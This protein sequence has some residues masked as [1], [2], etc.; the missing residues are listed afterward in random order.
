MAA[1]K[2]FFRPRLAASGGIARPSRA[3]EGA[4]AR[5]FRELVLPHLDG[6]YNFARYLTRDPTAAE[7]DELNFV[8][9][10]YGASSADRFAGLFGRYF[11]GRI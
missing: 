9:L 8:R 3:D 10:V 1:Q 6:A 11:A 2:P 5:Q 7:C 4:Q